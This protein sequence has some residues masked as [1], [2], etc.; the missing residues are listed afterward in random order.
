MN[1]DGQYLYI[2]GN[3]LL[4]LMLS[5]TVFL[6]TKSFKFYFFCCELNKIRL[7]YILKLINYSLHTLIYLW[8]RIAI[9]ITL[10]LEIFWPLGVEIGILY[11]VNL[12]P[13]STKLKEK[14]ITR[15]SFLI[16]FLIKFFIVFFS[17]WA[18]ELFL[19]MGQ[20]ILPCP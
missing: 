12:F 15:K 10:V 2:Y 19:C 5:K 9:E 3:E 13:V 8:A 4:S 6:T 7:T 16:F 1:C 18:T 11:N 20:K 14:K 17:K